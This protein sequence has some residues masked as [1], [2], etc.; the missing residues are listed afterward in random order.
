[1]EKKLVV[2]TRA[3]FFGYFGCYEYLQGLPPLGS[4]FHFFIE[5]VIGAPHLPRRALHP[6][7]INHYIGEV[8]M[9]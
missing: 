6:H 3:L 7:P 1:M 2:V 4:G 9:E 5:G 8:F